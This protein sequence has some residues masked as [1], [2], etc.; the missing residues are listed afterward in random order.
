MDPG[1]RTAVRGPAR[2]GA[3]MDPRWVQAL[4]ENVRRSLRS[5]AWDEA[6][7]GLAALEA[8]DPMSVDTR[9]LRL[10]LLV[11]TGQN[12]EAGPLARQLVETFPASPGVR[13]WAGRHCY[14]LGD[15]AAAVAHLTEAVARHPGRWARLWLGKALTQAG[16]LQEAERLLLDFHATPPGCATDLAWLYERMDRT[17]EAI[18]LLEARVAD[19][20]LD[21]F[22][23]RQLR[24]LR[25]QTLD[26]G[27]ILAEVET[28]L[29]LA[30]PVPDDL[31]VPYV[32][33]LLR[34][35]RAE[36]ARAFV[37]AR[38]HLPGKVLIGV[39]FACNRQQTPDLAM[40]VFLEGFEAGLRSDA[41][42]PTLEKCARRCSRVQELCDVYAANA[43][44][45]PKLYERRRKLLKLL[46]SG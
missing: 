42:L 44:R 27:T 26:D 33:A 46:P 14:Q 34:A 8:A 35:G 20:P 21:G 28:R 1:S 29:E 36:D 43:A 30:E 39:G 25:A 19:A 45:H 7:D 16:Q 23:A 37:T 10:E 17:D 2:K 12:A 32:E 40:T 31:V 18:R 38:P 15:Y 6:R 9:G 5:R 24:R 22:A 11:R 41:F 3:E 4:R 13:Y